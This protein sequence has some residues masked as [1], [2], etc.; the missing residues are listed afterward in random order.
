[1]INMA[2]GTTFGIKPSTLSDIAIHTDH[3]NEEISGREPIVCNLVGVAIERRFKTM[4]KLSHHN[5][6]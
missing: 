4:K 1:M 3:W 6:Y 5:V 2:F